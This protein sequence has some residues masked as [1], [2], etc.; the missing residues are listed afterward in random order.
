MLKYLLKIKDNSMLKQNYVASLVEPYIDTTGKPRLIEPPSTEL[1]AIQSRIKVMLGN[2]SVPDYVFS[3]I[4]GRS[5]ADNSKLHAGI[6]FLFKIDLTAFFPSI[7]RETIFRFFNIDLEC[8]TDIA[9]VLT[10]FLTIDILKSKA[11]N[12]DAILR[13]LESKH[14]KVKNHLISGSPASQILSYLGNHMMFDELHTLSI[15]NNIVMTVYVDDITFSGIGY[16]S[17]RFKEKVNHI[18]RKY[19]YKISKAKVKSYSK[20]YPKLVTG[21]IIDSTG[22]L[23]LRNSLRRK[24]IIEFE[25]LRQNPTNSVSRNRLRGLIT[26][27][28]QVNTEI[29]PSIHKY[30]FEKPYQY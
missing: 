26:A 4:K 24:I 15:K 13:F 12:I 30:A 10:N 27:A 9:E 6:R 14:V 18:I 1:K 7:K 20:L 19:G 28:R 25:K 3:G 11:E 23:V 2:I 17:H 5:Y 29:Y 16:I 21:V 22:K 8:S